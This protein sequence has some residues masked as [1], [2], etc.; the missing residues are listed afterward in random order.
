[1]EPFNI[2]A[3]LFTSR[4]NRPRIVI[5]VKSVLRH[6][7]VT[8][9]AYRARKGHEDILLD[10]LVDR[11]IFLRSEQCVDQEKPDVEVVIIR[12]IVCH[13]GINV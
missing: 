8:H 2:A 12:E 6:I 5:S 10:D 11:L 3:S 13:V 7:D 4:H 9:S 1:M